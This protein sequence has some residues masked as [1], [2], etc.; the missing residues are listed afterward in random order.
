MLDKVSLFIHGLRTSRDKQAELILYSNP[1]KRILP[2][3]MQTPRDDS[4]ADSNKRKKTLLCL[5]PSLPTHRD[6][7]R[8]HGIAISPQPPL[9]PG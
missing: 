5:C 1:Q 2:T 3:C 9:D 7:P 8:L 4:R 6:R